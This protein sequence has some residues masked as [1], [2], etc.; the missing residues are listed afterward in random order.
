MKIIRAKDYKDMSRKAANIISAQVIMKPNCVLGLATGG[1]PVG[2]Y[3]QLVEWYNKGDLDFS[4]VT[5]VN[6]DEYRGLPK[7]HPE[8][9]WSF[10]HKNLF[11]HVNIRPEAIHLP[12]GTNPDAADACKKY[13]EIIHSVDD[14]VVLCAGILCIGVGAV[15]QVDLGR[16]DVHLIEQILVHEAPVA[17]RVLL[18]QAA[19]LVQIDGGHLR[20]IDVALVVPVHQL[21]IR[22]NGGAAGRQTQHAVGLHNDLCRNDIGCL[23]G[24]IRI[25][26]C[27]ND[28]HHKRP[29][30][31]SFF[32]LCTGCAEHFCV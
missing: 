32:P 15:R 31:S 16:V 29:H 17:F 23:A 1:T 12:D 4:E 27:T 7:E 6:L 3:A 11:D 28:L 18:G 26:L 19:V 20:K 22:A 24:H 2:A 8:S 14:L 5:T 9:Y 25:I 13:N 30:L 21:C 10:M